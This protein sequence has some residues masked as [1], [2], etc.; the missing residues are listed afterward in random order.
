[1][2]QLRSCARAIDDVAA[3]ARHAPARLRDYRTTQ[4][5]GELAHLLAGAHRAVTWNT[6]AGSRERILHSHFV[7]K[8]ANEF[9]RCARCAGLLT[10]SSRG[11]L[12]DLRKRDDAVQ[13]GETVMAPQ[14]RV[15]NG[16]GPGEP[17]D[18]L[19]VTATVRNLRQMLRNRDVRYV[20]GVM[21]NVRSVLGEFADASVDDQDLQDG[22]RAQGIGYARF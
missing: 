2:Q 6:N 22:L 19:D 17:I 8:P 7:A 16:V 5:D 13:S 11:D 4:R 10:H 20:V 18:D 15:R 21:I 12:I 1:M 9:R 3:R 14:S